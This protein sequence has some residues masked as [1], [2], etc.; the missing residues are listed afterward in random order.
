MPTDN[1]Q[2]E[3]DS[4]I[5]DDGLPKDELVTS[6]DDDTG[7]EVEVVDDTPEQDRGVSAVKNPEPDDDEL[8]GYNEKVQKR[9]NDLRHAY[10]DERRRA[11]A[12][13]REK[14]AAIE[15]ARNIQG[16][17]QQNQH[18][19][20]QTT[21]AFRTLQTKLDTARTAYAEA[22]AKLSRAG[23]LNLGWDE[24]AD[25][26]EKMTDSRIQVDHFTRSIDALEKMSV[27]PQQP[28]VQSEHPVQQPGANRPQPVPEPDAST[29]AWMS[30]NKW[31]GGKDGV[32]GEMT[33]IAFSTHER[34]VAEGV[35]PRENPDA[36]YRAIDKRVR[37]VFP[38]YN[39]PERQAQQTATKNHSR[40]APAGRGAPTKT[41]KI[42]LT[43][44][45]A[46]IARKLG[47]PLA[48]YARQFQAINNEK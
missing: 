28:V 10:H 26:Q 3:F 11:E 5:G 14:D 31:F 27:Q 30:R 25:L 39:W 18:N 6:T 45:Q 9:I 42:T 17:L 7:I 29:R 22:K 23:E 15:Y 47:V 8:S 24:V 33:A 32:E 19:V 36:Y 13:Q 44:S 2:D 4:G 16:Q 12:A 37:E 34:L 1:T 35:D 21:G 48:E 20:S 41:G 38:T 40:V 46:E 43:K